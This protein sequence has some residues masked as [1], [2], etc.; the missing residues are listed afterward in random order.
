[1][2]EY[3]AGLCVM[4]GTELVPVESLSIT[5]ADDDE[6]RPKGYRMAGRDANHHRSGD[7]APGAS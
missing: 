6:G 3:T 5:A 7:L 4:E 2:P 1:M